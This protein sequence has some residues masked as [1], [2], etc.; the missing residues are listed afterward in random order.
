MFWDYTMILVIPAILFAMY[1]QF[2][3]NSA[4]A[5]YSK[6]KNANGM[7]GAQIAERILELNGIRDVKVNRIGGK[8]TD[9]YD[10]RSRELNLSE[11]VYDSTSVAAVGIA[12]HEVGHAIQH[13]TGY[14]A[15]NVRNAIFPVVNIGSNMAMPV[16]LI[17]MLISGLFTGMGEF[18]YLVMQL[19]IVMFT[20]VLAFQVIT[21]PVEFNASKRA[22]MALEDNN[23]LSGEEVEPAKKVLGAA[24]LTYV[25]AVAVTLT[26][27][28]RMLL[29]AGKRR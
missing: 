24:A 15:L 22:I 12:A 18:G 20:L 21:L 2:K 29:L 5:R 14:I 16:F 27:L 17:G 10:P 25:A 1:A 8:L 13:D 26:Q 19:G 4:F 23:L 9:H 7:T 28:L 6:L 3:V 11:S